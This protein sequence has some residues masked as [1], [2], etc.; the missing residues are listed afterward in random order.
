MG[1]ESPLGSSRQKQ[2][3]FRRSVAWLF[4]QRHFH[5]KLLSGTAVGVAVIILLA[6]IFLYVTWRNHQQDVIREQAIQIIR[7]SSRIENDIAALE[8]GHRGFLL[9]GKRLYL[10][11]F[12]SRRELIKRRTDDL[13]SLIL[14][15]Q[16][17][18]KR[19]MKAGAD[20][21][22]CGGTSAYVRSR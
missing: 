18:R 10:D 11:A 5:F 22:S 6:G 1:P 3:L 20:V 7:Q 17:Q 19:L 16:N 9:T 13:S 12:E 14:S 2:G 4:S 21:Q 8:A 15:D